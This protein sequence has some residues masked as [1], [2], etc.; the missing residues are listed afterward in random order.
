MEADTTRVCILILNPPKI[1]LT[2]LV[3]HYMYCTYKIKHP[4]NFIRLEGISEILTDNSETSE[5]S[6]HE[7][8]TPA[9]AVELPASVAFGLLTGSLAWIALRQQPRR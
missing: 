1:R 4:S 3:T 9:T 6:G 2:S 7:T 8:N 5:Q